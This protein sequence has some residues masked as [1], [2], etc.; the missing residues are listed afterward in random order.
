[1]SNTE[2]KK[3]SVIR[4]GDVPTHTFSWGTLTWVGNKEVLGSENL[5]VGL[6]TINPGKKNPKHYHPNCEEVLYMAEGEVDHSLGDQVFHLKAGDIIRIPKDV[7]HDALNTG[8][9]LVRM[10]V[11]Y[12]SGTRETVVVED[13]TEE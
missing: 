6:V 10:V 8:T 5:T 9:T 3:P 2:V 7:H 4:P 11:T 1:M 13:S 12:D